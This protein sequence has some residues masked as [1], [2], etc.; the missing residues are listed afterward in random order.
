MTQ[1]SAQQ[2]IAGLTRQ[3]LEEIARSIEDLTPEDLHHLPHERANS[4]G[5]DAWHVTRT[6]DNL[7]NFAFLRERPVWLQQRL[8]AEWDLPRVE[9]GTGMPPDE[10]RALR[11]P[12]AADLARY[13]REVGSAVGERIEGFTDDFLAEEMEI[14]FVGVRSRWMVVTDNGLLHGGEHLG[15]INLARTLLGRPTLDI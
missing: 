9:Q 5:F 8:D 6:L 3:L 2:L 4:I 1:G 7:I 13:V 10:A 14:K 12:P 15:Q 11:F